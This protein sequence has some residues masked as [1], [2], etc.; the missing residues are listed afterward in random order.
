MNESKNNYSTPTNLAWYFDTQV[1]MQENQKAKPKAHSTAHLAWYFDTQIKMQQNQKTKTKANS[2]AEK[3]APVQRVR[4]RRKLKN[5]TPVKED[6]VNVQPQSIVPVTNKPSYLFNI[7]VK[8]LADYAK[9][10]IGSTILSNGTIA[11]FYKPYNNGIFRLV[12]TCKVFSDRRYHILLELYLDKS[13]LLLLS[14]DVMFDVPVIDSSK[15]FRNVVGKIPI[16]YL[17][18]IFGS[19]QEMLDCN[20]YLK[21][22]E[23]QHL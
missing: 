11:H 23:Y 17:A 19:F 7:D 21:L 6:I 9:N 20:K 13:K 8:G 16:K 10:I 5:V 22:K 12:F 15:A 1:K 4:R 3:Q 14:K 2:I 18:K